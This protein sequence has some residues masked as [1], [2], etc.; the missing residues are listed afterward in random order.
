MFRPNNAHRHQNLFGFQGL[1]PEEMGKKLEESVEY[2]FYQL[3]F[4]NIGE[5]DFAG[6]YSELESRPN[7]PVNCLVGALFL[8][9]RRGWSY[10]ELFDNISFNLLT[11]TALGLKTVDE[12]PFSPA[13]IFNF[14]TRLNDH[15]IKTG[16]NLLERVF[17]SLT[18]NQLKELR[19][20]T[21][22][23]RTDSFQAASNIRSY[24][25]LQLLVEMVI[26]V[27]RVLK[28]GDRKKFQ[29]LFAPYIDKTS[30]QY[31]YQL[32][33]GELAGEFERLAA[34]YHQI[35][36][37]LRPGYHSCQIFRTFARVYAEHF[38]VVKDTL[39][40]KSS[41]QLN[42][43]CLQSPDDLEATYRKKGKRESRGQA[44]NIVETAHPDNPLNLI[45]DV[46]VNPNNVDDSRALN[47][48]LDT[49]K[50]KTS[51]LNELHY[52]GAYPSADNDRKC[53]HHKIV[54]IQTGIK[55]PAPSGVQI[56]IDKL[57][58]D[59]YGV[60]CPGQSLAAEKTETGYKAILAGAACAGCPWAGQCQWAKGRTYYFTEE[61]YLRKKRLGN[62]RQLPKERRTLRSNV[63]A[64]VR[65]FK[66]K[67]PGGKLK[68]RGG[69]KTAVF[70]MSAAVIIN[71]GRIVRYL[72]AVF[73]CK[74]VGGRMC[75]E[76]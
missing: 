14:Q 20:K 76:T 58:K 74:I 8:M 38:T 59:A 5:E 66:R 17:D 64:S 16:E 71:F 15:F 31:I 27:H 60:S 50:E 23:Q 10:R 19:L 7:A 34:V 9:Q 72:D 51:D 37:A 32:K 44:V 33:P 11:K 47:Q 28:P 49:L 53:R 75:F 1:I 56:T 62:I 12:Q 43:G 40:V 35:D 69:F 26:R 21:D 6:L 25:R 48:R 18:A 54:Q 3:I 61:D 46:A 39:K 57:G 13:T 52:D 55:G 73:D 29:E 2:K 63:E 4:C 67:M 30:S 65:E 42:S 41:E 36:R 24:T 70:A 68:V 22:I 45:T